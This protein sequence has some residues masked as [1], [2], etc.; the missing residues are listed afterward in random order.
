MNKIEEDPIL[1]R[2]FDTPEKKVKWLV[3]IK[4]FYIIWIIFI[5]IGIVF[6]F[7]YYYL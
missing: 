3:R 7:F 5:I 1:G 4:I 2:F 6:L